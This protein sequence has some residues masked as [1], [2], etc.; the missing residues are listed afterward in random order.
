MSRKIQLLFCFVFIRT[1]FFGCG[2]Q[3]KLDNKPD[4][5]QYLLGK[6]DYTKDKDFVQLDSIFTDDRKD[7]YLRKE[8]YEA[9]KKMFAAAFKDSVKLVIISA[10]RS[11]DDQ[12]IIWENKWNGKATINGKR[13]PYNLYTNVDKAKFILQSGSMPGTSRHHWGTDVDLNSTE[14][15]Y[16]ETTKGK[17]IYSWL[18][19]NAKKFGFYQPYTPFD[20]KRSKGYD[21]EMWHWSYL[22]SAKAILENYRK[23]ITYKDFTGFLGADAAEKLHVIEDYVMSINSECK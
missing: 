7:F 10:E 14:K 17:L 20:S 5:K 18:K 6:F 4:P 15:E 21:E 12:K 8:T 3:T 2:A 13:I 9:Y 1:N 23:N 22:P 16:F 11:F 19:Q